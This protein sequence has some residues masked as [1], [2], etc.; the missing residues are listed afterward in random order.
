MY[1]GIDTELL[2]WNY[3]VIHIDLNEFTFRRNIVHTPQ[4]HL[5]FLTIKKSQ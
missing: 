1:T 3:T 4:N 5:D 2:F